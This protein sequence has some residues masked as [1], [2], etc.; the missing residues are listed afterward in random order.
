[1]FVTGD[2]SM[3]FQQNLAKRK[4]GMLVLCGTSNALEDLLPLIPA[5]LIALAAIQSGQVVRIEA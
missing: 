3:P 1:M 2:Q 5:A 4:L